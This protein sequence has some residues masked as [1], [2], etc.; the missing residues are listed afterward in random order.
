MAK[1]KADDFDLLAGMIYKY[2]KKRGWNIIVLSEP[3]VTQDVGARDF[4]FNLTF[5]FTG[6]QIVEIAKKIK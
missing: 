3:S 5:R 6:K 1:K 2:M 4:N